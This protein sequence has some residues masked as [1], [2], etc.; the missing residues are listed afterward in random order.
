MK[1]FILNISLALSG[2]AGMCGCS[3]SFLDHEATDAVTDEIAKEPS[4]AERVFNGA[5]YNLFEDT[6]TYANMGYRAFMCQDDMMGNDVVSRPMYGFNSS[7]QYT[8]VPDPTV[9][10]TAFAWSLLYKTIHNCNLV[11]SM[12]LPEGEDA[13]T[14]HYSQGKALAL[15]AF[16]YLHLAQHYQFTYLKDKTA[17]CV[18][19]YTEPNTTDSQ[20]KARSTVEEV[21]ERILDDLTDAK[22]FLANYNRNGVMF[23]PNIDVVNGL[24][25]RTHLLMGNWTEAALAAKAARK[26]Y[27]LMNEE[28]YK[29]GF[30][31][32]KNPE[33][34]WAHL[35]TLDQS[36]ASYNF[37][38]IDVV[39][40]DSYNSFMAD[41]HFM[42][43][44]SDGDYRKDLFQWMRE[45]YLG[46][47]KFRI[48]DDETGDILLMRSSEM[49]LIEAEAE[50]R[51]H[52]VPAAELILDELLK[53]R[54]LAGYTAN[55]KS[56]SEVIE[57]IL[58]ER[59]KEL[60]GEGFAITDILRTQKAVEREPLTKAEAENK[61]KCWQEDGKEK[62]FL[63]QGH[64]ITNLPDESA[65]VPNSRYYLYAIPQKEINANPNIQ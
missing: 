23:K 27:P 58:I 65:F 6:Y 9:S 33:W 36:N 60:W 25:A 46:Y 40:S 45:G 7:Y 24:L 42:N 11:I 2:L 15:R 17:P 39:V 20:P 38:Y 13:T 12:K 34:M 49:Y 8:D 59:R 30:S 18:P 19:V 50:A 35:Q 44:F 14:L 5:W 21:Y 41:P 3:G 51:N 22:A 48:R 32:A 64:W 47:R 16:C 4:N 28:E 61:V 55:G 52:N 10:R 37:Y 54:G 57:D 29:S 62:E 43:L 53:A 31:D 63:P 1:K 26:G 56:E